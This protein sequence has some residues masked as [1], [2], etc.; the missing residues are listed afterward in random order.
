MNFHHHK[1]PK[2]HKLPLLIYD[3]TQG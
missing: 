3:S 1:N 2:S